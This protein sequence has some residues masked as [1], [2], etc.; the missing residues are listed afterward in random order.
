[1]SRA[2]VHHLAVAVESSPEPVEGVVEL[3]RDLLAR[4][5]AG[6]IRGVAVV[7]I[8][9]DKAIG[10]GHQHDRGDASWVSLL[11]GVTCL[12]AMLVEDRP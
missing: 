6:E 11:G 7:A 8:T 5:E 4:A 9:G 1:M 12:Q 10:Y 3:L 2:T